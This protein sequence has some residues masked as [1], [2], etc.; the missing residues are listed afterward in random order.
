MH[1]VLVPTENR[2][3]GLLSDVLKSEPG[4]GN[5]ADQLAIKAKEIMSKHDLS[6][7]NRPHNDGNGSQ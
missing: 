1:V 5:E 4:R 3:L 2:I 7:D 6:I